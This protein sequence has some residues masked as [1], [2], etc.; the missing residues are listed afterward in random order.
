MNISRGSEAESAGKLCAEIA[1]N[2]AEEIAGYDDAKLPGIANEL[3]HESVDVKMARLDI[4]IFI[5]YLRK[6]A[7][8]EFVPVGE[9]IGFV[10]HADAAEL[11]FTGVLESVANDSL[12]SPAGIDVSLHGD[13][14]RGATLELAAHAYVEPFGIFAENDK[15]DIACVAIAQR[16]QCR[17]DEF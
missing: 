10:A 7:Q 3:H 4:C 12:H 8:P 13:L 5:L 9:R 17:I 6:H 1:E 14:V 16:G 11:M 2:V 15:V